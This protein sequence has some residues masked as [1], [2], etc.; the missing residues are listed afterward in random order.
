MHL[1]D[2]KILIIMEFEVFLDVSKL[3]WILLLFYL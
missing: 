1:K 3:P 2:L